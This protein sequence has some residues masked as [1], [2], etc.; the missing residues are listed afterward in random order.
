MRSTFRGFSCLTPVPKDRRHFIWW[1]MISRNRTAWRFHPM[2]ERFTCVIPAVIISGPLMSNRM[3][4]CALAP[5]ASLQ[6][7]TRV[8]PGG[9]DGMKVDAAGRVY[10]AVALGIWVFEPDGRLLGILSMPIRPSNLAW[11]DSDARGLAITAVDAVYH[12]RLRVEGLMP[13]FMP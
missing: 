12:V 11:C 10:V 4:R 3:D 8:E 1:Q 9:P 7:S 2:S 6:R 13:P 5:A